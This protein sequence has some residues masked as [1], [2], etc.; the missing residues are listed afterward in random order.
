MNRVPGLA[1]AP[2]GPLSMVVSGTGGSVTANAIAAW[3]ATRN[4]ARS[5]IASRGLRRL[6]R[7]RLN[8][9]FLR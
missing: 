6:I 1:M 2:L 4:A 8:K 7:A 5:E 9:A 3:Q